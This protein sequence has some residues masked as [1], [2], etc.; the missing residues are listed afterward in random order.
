MSNTVGENT[1]LQGSLEFPVLFCFCFQ[2]FFFYVVV[3][4]LSVQ[5]YFINKRCTPTQK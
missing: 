1:V 3:L 2:L 4:S 5:V